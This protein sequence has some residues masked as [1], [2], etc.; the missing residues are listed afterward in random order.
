MRKETHSSFG[1]FWRELFDA[2]QEAKRRGGGHLG[3]QISKT[4][5]L[6]HF[7]NFFL[8]GTHL[9]DCKLVIL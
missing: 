6:G 1:R 3:R 2:K 4:P 8:K 5:F 7:G 9:G